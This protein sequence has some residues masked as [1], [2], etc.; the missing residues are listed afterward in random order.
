MIKKVATALALTA[1]VVCVSL[2][3]PEAGS[4]NP[5]NLVYI[6]ATNAGGGYDA[7]A[8]M[9]GGHMEPYLEAEHIVIRNVPGAGH[10]VGANTLWRSKPDGLTI[11]TFNSGLIYGQL[12]GREVQRFDLA[13]FEWIGKAAAEARAVVVSN[14]CAV[15]NVADLLAAEMPVKFASA[16]IGSAADADI[17][18][19]AQALDL[20]IDPI[21]GYGGTEGEMSMMRGEVCAILGSVSSLQGFVDSGYGS[22][23][24][25]IGESMDGVPNAMDFARTERAREIIS[26][27][28]AVAELGRISAAPPATPRESVDV[29]RRAYKSTLEDPVF[30]ADAERMGRPIDPAYGDDVRNRIIAA[31]DQSPE[32]G[33]IITQSVGA[34]FR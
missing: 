29:L 22:F 34:E 19:L 25:T 10:I 18:L 13:E 15:K 9:I 24:L 27:I 21:T 28:E 6:V 11:G 1:V 31:L 26:L 5:E 20:N 2:L 4:D 30:L 8:R 14:Q 33:A 23:I 12:A 17:R 7:Y 16:G 3:G 32:I